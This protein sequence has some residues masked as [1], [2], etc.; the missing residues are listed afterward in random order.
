LCEHLLM[1]GL[2]TVLYKGVPLAEQALAIRGGSGYALLL[3]CA[4][5]GLAAWLDYAADAGLKTPNLVLG[6]LH[7]ADAD[8]AAR[9]AVLTACRRHGVKRL[10]PGHCTGQQF[11]DDCRATAGKIE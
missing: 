2:L 3:G 6:G 4:H 1:L 10:A 9:A 7:L 8:A 11:V 5:A